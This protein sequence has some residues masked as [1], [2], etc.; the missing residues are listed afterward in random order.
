MRSIWL[1]RELGRSQAL[2]LAYAMVGLG[3]NQDSIAEGQKSFESGA[4]PEWRLR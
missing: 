2:A 4:R 1:A 3:T